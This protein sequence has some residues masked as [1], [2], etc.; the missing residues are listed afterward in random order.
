MRTNF[1]SQ[2]IV[3]ESKP[4]VLAF[5]GRYAANSIY[6]DIKEKCEAITV[7][8]HSTFQREINNNSL[9]VVVC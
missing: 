7:K 8:F 6:C 2:P 3:S 4:L 9:S 5:T 1:S